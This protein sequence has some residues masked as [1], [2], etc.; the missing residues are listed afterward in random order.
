[1]VSVNGNVSSL[2]RCLVIISLKNAHDNP[3]S[4]LWF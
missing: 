4:L 1:M 2:K 3:L